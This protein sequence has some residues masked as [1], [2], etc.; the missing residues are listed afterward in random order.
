MLR[1]NAVMLWLPGWRDK[2]VIANIN[3]Q[4]HCHAN[5]YVQLAGETSIVLNI[6][7]ITITGQ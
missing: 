6:E 3:K 7:N 5:I 2:Q 4:K 1:N